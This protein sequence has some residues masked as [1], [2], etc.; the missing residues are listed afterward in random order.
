[1][2]FGD[3]SRIN[4]NVQAQ[5]ANTFLQRTNQDIGLRQ[6]R[7]ATGSQLNRAEDDSA[8]YSISK[9]LE[10]RVR[11]Q[12]QALSNVGD[13][14]SMLTVGEGALN[15]VMDILQTMKEKSVQ[16]ANDTMGTQ[17][18]TAIQNQVD[19]LRTE[20]EDV[21][22]G[23]TFNGTK[24]FES[25]NPFN[26][27]VGAESGENFAV[28]IAQLDTDGLL[29]EV[30]EAAGTV[31][32]GTW[33]GGDIE[34]ASYSGTED[35]TYN[36]QVN[37]STLEYRI[38][39]AGDWT[40]ATDAGNGEFQAGDLRVAVD[41]T[42]AADTN[43]FDVAATA[44]SGGLVVNSHEN[45]SASIATVDAAINLISEQ[46]ANIGDS[47]QRLTFKQENLQVSMTNYESARSR[48]SDADFA[49]EQMELVKL[50]ILQQ[51]GT[52][53]LAQANS[54]PQAVLSLF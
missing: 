48:I 19:A 31:T 43:T 29:G 54:A 22:G 42:G 1:M 27:Q 49:K 30:T 7:L 26:F 25:E 12:A 37:G 40:A 17:E 50:Q 45:A 5:Q 6:L 47:Q 4:T 15:T 33:A 2:S 14:K 39:G 21:L 53:A 11:G 24:L 51:T 35:L 23:T 38:G 9:K 36:F 44:L 18:R 46:L 20:I 8:G 52:A 3:L 41:M 28:T 32:E 34:F 13:A 10:A 16:A